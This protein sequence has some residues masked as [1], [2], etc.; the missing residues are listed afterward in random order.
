[1][2][3]FT[4]SEV[5]STL[6][7]NVLKCGKGPPGVGKTLTVETLAKSSGKPLYVI[8]ASDIGVEPEITE[9]RLAHILELAER[10]GAVLLMW[11][12]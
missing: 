11:V 5:F 6:G 4:V 1:M 7:F 9:R 2:S 8:G 12:A 3:Y 10:W